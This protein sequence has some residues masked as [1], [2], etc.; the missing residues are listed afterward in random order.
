[1]NRVSY[2]RTLLLGVFL[3]LLMGL[4]ANSALAQFAEPQ[5][6]ASFGNVLQPIKA[7]F[8]PIINL[9]GGASK[10]DAFQLESITRFMLWIIT[11]SI[12]Y[13]GLTKTNII[14]NNIAI[15]LAFCFAT[16]SAIFMPSQLVLQVGGTW[17]QIAF[18]ILLSPVFFKGD[19]M[20][21]QKWLGV[22]IIICGVSL[23][24][25]GRGK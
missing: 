1:M 6:A 21:V 11:F 2:S 25:R 13:W 22:L 19:F 12:F 18:M 24:S 4:F 16:I 15:A 23:V 3:I 7:I 10:L 20:T 8:V 14:Q 5:G 9:F 17:G